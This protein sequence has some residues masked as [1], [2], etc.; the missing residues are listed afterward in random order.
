MKTVCSQFDIM[1]YLFVI[2]HVTRFHGNVQPPTQTG[3]RFPLKVN[4]S[5]RVLEI[6]ITVLYLGLELDGIQIV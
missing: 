5:H 1:N 3:L 6:Q 4:G 2:K